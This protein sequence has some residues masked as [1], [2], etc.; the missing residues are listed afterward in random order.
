MAGETVPMSLRDLEKK[1]RELD[2]EIDQEQKRAAELRSIRGLA[3]KIE[4]RELE[5]AGLRI[6]L[7]ER[8]QAARA[9]GIPLSRLADA[10]KLSKGRIHQ[11][12]K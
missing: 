2:A 9:L 4:N 11:L 10:A 8:L 6:Q 1:R 12:T 3:V 5:V 7:F